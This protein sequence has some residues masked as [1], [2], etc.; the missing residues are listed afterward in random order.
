[1]RLPRY[2]AGKSNVAEL[3]AGRNA[4]ISPAEAAQAAAAKYQAISEGAA[5][6]SQ[7]FEVLGDIKANEEYTSSITAMQG[8][9]NELDSEIQNRPLELDENGLIRFDTEE[10]L[11]E[12][13]ERRAE[14][15][16]RYRTNIQSGKAQRMFDQQVQEVGVTRDASYLDYAITRERDILSNRAEAEVDNHVLNHEYDAAI[17]RITLARTNLNMSQDRFRERKHQILTERDRW[18]VD[19]VRLNEDATDKEIE[20]L[21]EALEK[22]TWPAVLGLSNPKMA[23]DSTERVSL[24]NSLYSLEATIDARDSARRRGEQE[25]NTLGELRLIVE[26][27]S[28]PERIVNLPLN[29]VNEAQRKYLLAQ[30]KSDE[31]GFKSDVAVRTGYE[32]D[33]LTVRVDGAQPAYVDRLRQ[34]IASDDRLSPK[35]ALALDE[36]LTKTVNAVDGDDDDRRVLD[37]ELIKL[38][39]LTSEDTF[40]GSTD[41][42][43]SERIAGAAMER[44][45]WAAKQTLGA[46][47]NA[48]QWLETNRTRYYKDALSDTMIRKYSID[49]GTLPDSREDAL[50]LIEAGV[51]AYVIDLEDPRRWAEFTEE[52]KAEYLSDEMIKVNALLRDAYAEGQ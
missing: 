13:T 49:L 7:V 38:Q 3:Q 37:A 10:L 14:I 45:F 15:V 48:T 19:K 17:N 31:S 44:D 42:R 11:K 39:G 52:E 30:S 29:H 51:L 41:D 46:D 25:A 47:F 22:G 36:S 26:G 33:I 50:P 20:L 24:Q 43:R 4:I 8:E 27:K 23:I 16:E 35:D 40:M 1:M 6:A 18:Q 12:E 32:N 2:Q 21:T 9:L 28:S 34:K 5:S